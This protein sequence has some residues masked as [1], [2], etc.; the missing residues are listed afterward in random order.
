[1]KPSRSSGAVPSPP[2]GATGGHEVAHARASAPAGSRSP[3]SGYHTKDRH[4]H[5][6][7]FPRPCPSGQP[8]RGRPRACTPL[9]SWP[10]AKQS[11]ESRGSRHGYNGRTDTRTPT[12]AAPRSAPQRP[13]TSPVWCSNLYVRPGVELWGFEPQTSCMPCLTDPSDMIRSGRTR[14]GQDGSTV[15]QGPSPASAIWPRRH[16]VSH[17]SPDLASGDQ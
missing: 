14:A 5:G 8:N 16:L 6:H 11:S 3:A 17:W 12:G 10:P 13:I 1:M 15:P 7:K 4:P 2:G 9:T